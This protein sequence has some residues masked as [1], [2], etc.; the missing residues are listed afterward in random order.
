MTKQMASE[1][2]IE[3]AMRN[4][5]EHT[6]D[7]GYTMSLMSERQYRALERTVRPSATLLKE[8][9]ERASKA[10]KTGW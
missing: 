6:K 3:A 4:V 10:S 9:G 2:E 8:A 7:G 5:W 1:A